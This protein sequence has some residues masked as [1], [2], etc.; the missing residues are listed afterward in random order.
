MATKTKNAARTAPPKD[1]AEQL[2]GSPQQAES[3]KA[4]RARLAEAEGRA[5]RAE[6]RLREAGLAEDIAAGVRARM[7]LGLTREQAVDAET[8]QQAHDAVLRTKYADTSHKQTALIV[9]AANS[10]A[11][12]AEE[13]RDATPATVMA[14]KEVATEAEDRDRAAREAAAKKQD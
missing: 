13:A 4:L 7:A 5:A 11:L 6:G 2:D 1:P 9:A 12:T 10:R 3:L 8:R 14:V